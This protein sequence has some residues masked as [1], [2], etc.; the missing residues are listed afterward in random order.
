MQKDTLACKHRLWKVHVYKPDLVFWTEHGY[1]VGS[2]QVAKTFTR[3]YSFKRNDYEYKTLNEN[4]LPLEVS[5]ITKKYVLGF[6][7]R[8]K[9]PPHFYDSVYFPSPCYPNWQTEDVLTSK[10][11]WSSMWYNCHSRFL[12]V[13]CKWIGI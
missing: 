10:G 2:E 8:W 1:S 6:L 3:Y 9:V 5:K 12:I 7:P 4:H 11:Y 13:H